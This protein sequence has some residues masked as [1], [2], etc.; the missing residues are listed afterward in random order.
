ME[1]F[2]K[3]KPKSDITEPKDEV[4]YEDEHTQL[5][6]YDDWT[7]LKGSDAVVCI[8]YLIE[9]NKIILRNEY[10]PPFKYVDNKDHFLTLVSGTIETGET[11]KD[12]LIR[13]LE[14]E[15]GIVLREDYNE[16][17]EFAPLFMVKSCTAKYHPF[18][19]PLNER[20]YH[21]ITAKGDGSKAEKL[22]NSVKIDIKYLSSLLPSDLITDYMLYKLKEYIKIVK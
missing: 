2:S 7:I 11:P 5:I 8:P 1:R 14:E 3:M 22:S 17:E 15:A 6:K 12:T 18:I 19:L 4:L 21:E 20:D 16:F 13:E 9:E 10:V